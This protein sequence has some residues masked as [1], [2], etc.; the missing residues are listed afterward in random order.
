MTR[1]RID[2]ELVR[3][4]LARSREQ[5]HELLAAGRVELGGVVA[6][7]AATQVEPTASLVVQDVDEGPSY[8]SRGAHKLFGAL[9]AFGLD[10]TGRLALDAGASTG[11]F[12]DVLLRGGVGHVLA[13]DVGYG[14][15]AWAI[16]A[17]TS[18]SPCSSGP[19][20]GT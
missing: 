1:R 19:T 14:Q 8:V 12:C 5:A 13:V 2:A 20:C 6:S 9:A 11:G 15:L 17:P 18:G 3:R 7:K 10:V 16:C 4:G